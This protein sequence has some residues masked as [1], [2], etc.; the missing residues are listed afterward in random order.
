MT[1]MNL[2]DIL[3]EEMG[4]AVGNKYFWL[5]A[6]HL[7]VEE[8]TLTAITAGTYLK[9]ALLYNKLEVEKALTNHR[10]GEKLLNTVIPIA[11]KYEVLS[12][13]NILPLLDLTLDNGTSIIRVS[14]DEGQFKGKPTDKLIPGNL[15]TSKEELVNFL[16]R[17]VGKFA[18]IPSVAEA[19]NAQ[20][21]SGAVDNI[22][23]QL[24]VPEYCK[25]LTVGTTFEYSRKGERMRGVVTRGPF[26]SIS[27][28]WKVR[29]DLGS[30]GSADLVCSDLTAPTEVA[31]PEKQV[32]PTDFTPA[33]SDWIK[34]G[35]VCFHNDGI[36]TSRVVVRGEPMFSFGDWLVLV[37]FNNSKI[38]DRVRCEY[39]LPIHKDAR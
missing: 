3:A 30:Y 29:A 14:S 26:L 2:V 34:E 10:H 7:Q 19:V 24:Q 18:T 32:T 5:D 28:R 35:V 15:F 9:P 4:L 25:W 20:W 36:Q 17:K 8:Y 27:D 37:M 16:L 31:E 33:I 22:Q 23:D 12:F 13:M 6:V 38:E 11:G 39:L 21:T 1:H